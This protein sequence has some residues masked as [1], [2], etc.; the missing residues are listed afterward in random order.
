MLKFSRV[1]VCA[2]CFS[3]LINDLCYS[4]GSE[5]S[6]VGLVDLNPYIIE[7]DPDLPEPE[8]WL[9]CRFDGFELISNVNVELIK[10]FVKDI[11]MHREAM[12]VVRP[13]K[14]PPSIENV[15]ILCAKRKDYL[16]LLGEEYIHKN[17]PVTVLNRDFERNYYIVDFET[18]YVQFDGIATRLEDR[19]RVK[20]MKVDPIRGIVRQLLLG[21]Y[22]INSIGDE[23]AWFVEGTC[24]LMM[25]LEVKP[26]EIRYGRIDNRKNGLVSLDSGVNLDAEERIV[27][28]AKEF[29]RMKSNE[30]MFY[31]GG[32]RNEYEYVGDRPFHTVLRNE[33]LM[34]L[35]DLFSR[36]I[37]PYSD[38]YPDQNTLWEKE[39]YAFVYMCEFAFKGKYRDSIKG[40]LDELRQEEMSE[41]LFQKH[42]QVGYDEMLKIMKTYLRR[43][44]GRYNIYK[45]ER[46]SE[47]FVD[48]VYL[49]IATQ[50]DVARI[51]GN[52]KRLAGRN[53]EAL[54]EFRIA[55]DRGE[56]DLR[57]LEC[58]GI[59]EFEVGR[60][61]RCRGL[62]ETALLN[63]SRR[64]L[65][66]ICFANLRIYDLETTN[67]VCNTTLHESTEDILKLILFARSLEPSLPDV[68][69]AA[70]R[71]LNFCSQEVRDVV[72]ELIHE[73][74]T[75]YPDDEF[76]MN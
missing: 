66:W 70:A 2:F 71:L 47:I 44:H 51:K 15:I 27:D 35:E 75:M 16:Q 40:L 67:E 55:Y 64:P 20:E 43:P 68:Y 72:M 21:S 25:D 23:P 29:S 5:E 54:E 12:Q 61:D 24:Q 28:I 62:L 63:G 22:K 13:V 31:N 7:V 11:R 45:L 57:L 53:D 8:E 34:P 48:E 60:Y 18:Q 50:S 52:A 17:L 59:Q 65:V 58:L 6:D 3:G 38:D 49:S 42:F 9:Y 4:R 39:C 10:A 30:V 69:K 19:T 41:Q 32:R 76:L 74:K 33:K 46:D 56:R 14:C 1:L 73:G 26:D 37:S 36:K